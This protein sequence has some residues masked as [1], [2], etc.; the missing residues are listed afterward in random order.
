[1]ESGSI[2]VNSAHHADTFDLNSWRK[3]VGYASQDAKIFNGL[4]LGNISMRSDYAIEEVRK[5]CE[6]YGLDEFF[7]GMPQGYLTLVGEEG[8]NLSGGQ[9]QLVGLAGAEDARLDPYYQRN[10]SSIGGYSSDKT[11]FACRRSFDFRKRKN[12]QSRHSKRF[13]PR[14]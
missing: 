7:T 11:S 10:H 5:S 3:A 6:K 9:K 2:L 8:L 14:I 13:T 4:L 1:M 12:H